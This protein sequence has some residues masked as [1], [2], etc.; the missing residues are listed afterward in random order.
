MQKTSFH[1]FSI[2]SIS[3]RSLSQGVRAS[4]RQKIISCA[5]E[6]PHKPGV[7]FQQC[8][9]DVKMKQIANRRGKKITHPK[10]HF[11]VQ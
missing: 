5:Q 9:K 4:I 10:M 2:S 7:K 1:F 11:F 3:K 8:H 6:K